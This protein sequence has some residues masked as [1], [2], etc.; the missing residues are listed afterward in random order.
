MSR[1]TRLYPEAASEIKREAITKAVKEQREA[2]AAFSED[3][4]VNLHDLEAVKERTALYLQNCET[5]GIVP[6]LLGLSARFGLSRRRV[7]SFLELYPQSPSAEFIDA[8]RSA[9]AAIIAQGATTRVL[10]APTSIFLLKN[11]GQGLQD[12]HDI[13]V[14]PREYEREPTF[15]E[16]QRRLMED[17][18]LESEIESEE[19]NA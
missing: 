12:K 4:K 18:A 5:N 15:E 9:C 1:E 8:F 3:T 19:I 16:I 7:Y 6:S 14:T 17:I 13:E 10:D 2:L 11:S